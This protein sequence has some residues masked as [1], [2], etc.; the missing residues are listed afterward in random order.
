MIHIKH[1]DAPKLNKPTFSVDGKL[2]EKLD[3][4]E[5]PKL[6]NKHNV[7]LFLGKAGSG[8]STL[9]ISF[10]KSKPLFKRIYHKIILFCP[11]NS[12]GSINNDF[13]GK[14][15]EEGDIYDELNLDNL[16]EAYDI[17]QAN[18]DE[19]LK[20][21]ILFDDVQKAMKGECEK[22]LLHMINNRRHASLSL[23]L[24]NQNYF[25]IPKQVRMSLT[26]MFVFKV[27][28]TEMN[29][30]LT[31]HLEINNDIFEKLQQ[32]LFKKPHEFFY[33]NTLTG[34]MFQ[35]WDEL[36]IEND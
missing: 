11:P 12:R 22:L 27:G 13:W 15:L 35:N 2:H 6:M 1:N 34:R 7:V 19:G 20:T 23:W 29:N 9:L 18:R 17:A 21:L 33:V 25:S 4:Y 32:I 26:D 28:K 16:Q 3:D 24:A 10:L 31:E 36:I 5:I 30:L 14:N 8:K